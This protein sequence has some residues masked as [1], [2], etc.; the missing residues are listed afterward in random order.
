LS[1]NRHGE[2]ERITYPT[3]GTSDLSTPHIPPVASTAKFAYDQTNRGVVNRWMSVDGSTELPPWHYEVQRETT[4]SYQIGP[5]HVK[6][7]APD[8]TWSEQLLYDRWDQR[9]APFGFGD[10]ALGRAHEERVY[11]ATNKLLRRKLT[12]WTNTGPQTI[13]ES[14]RA[15]CLKRFASSA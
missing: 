12:E 2:I 14:R 1:Y 9:S 7:F 10:I 5:Y 6:T 15:L 8:G 3:A 4:S 13:P 11:S